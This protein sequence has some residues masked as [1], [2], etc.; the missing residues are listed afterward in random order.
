M[1][2]NFECYTLDKDNNSF[3]ALTQKNIAFIRAIVNMDSA[4]NKAFNPKCGGSAKMLNGHFPESENEICEAIALIDNENSTHLS[5]NEGREKTAKFISDNLGEIKHK[6]VTGDKDDIISVVNDIARCVKGRSNI[7][8]ASKFCAFTNQ[9]CF[10]RDDFSIV[11]STLC[12]IL[13]YYE[14]VYGLN[15]YTEHYR[16]SKKQDIISSWEETKNKE[17]FYEEYHATIGLI[18]EKINETDTAYKIGRADFDVLL[19]YCFKNNDD[20]IQRALNHLKP[21]TEP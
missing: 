9:H 15:N 6:I 7:S 5:V 13:P 18:I 3:P 12:K 20:Y 10:K 2:E 14:F 8:F 4:Y 11:D 1:S 21:K 19:W 16:I 17:G